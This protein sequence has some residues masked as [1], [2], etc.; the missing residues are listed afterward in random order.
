M[1]KLKCKLELFHEP[2]S[3]VDNSAFI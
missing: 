3:I 1:V 2:W